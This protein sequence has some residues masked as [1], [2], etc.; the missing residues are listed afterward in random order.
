[1]Q[2]AGRVADINVL[3][4][5]LACVGQEGLLVPVHHVVTHTASLVAGRNWKMIHDRSTPR[6]LTPEV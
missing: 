5:T 1:M 2:T 4:S 6:C 3:M